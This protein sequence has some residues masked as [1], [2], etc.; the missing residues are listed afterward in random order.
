[1]A[2]TP[3]AASAAVCIGHSSTTRKPDRDEA[4]SPPLPPAP[5]PQQGNKVTTL[6][7]QGPDDTRAYDHAAARNY[8]AGYQSCAGQSRV[9]RPIRS[10]VSARP[11]V[12][13]SCMAAGAPGM[14]T[15][16]VTREP[17]SWPDTVREPW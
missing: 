4:F 12:I 10:R 1:M 11:R 15:C 8:L 16:T 6:L 17:P 2:A 3:G 13:S 9:R 7:D 14:V 5:P